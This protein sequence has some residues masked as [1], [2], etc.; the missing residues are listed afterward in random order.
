[1]HG[2]FQRKL[3]KS[4]EN[5]KVWVENFKK[6]KSQIYHF[7][8]KSIRKFKQNSDL[9]VVLHLVTWIDETWITFKGKSVCVLLFIK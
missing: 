5:I 6:P 7:S 8:N 1:M 4:I 2:Y 9:S 3:T